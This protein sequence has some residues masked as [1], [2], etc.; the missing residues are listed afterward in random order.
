MASNL[1]TLKYVGH[2]AAIEID[3]DG[4]GDVTLVREEPIEVSSEVA[5]ELLHQVN[6]WQL[7]TV[8]ST[9]S[10]AIRPTATSEEAK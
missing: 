2:L 6:N 7:V 8:P 3:P 10:S 5:Q 1:V 4:L 9:K